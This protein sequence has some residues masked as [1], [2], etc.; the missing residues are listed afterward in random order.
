MSGTDAIL[1]TSSFLPGRGGIE[2]YLAA[3]ADRL[4]P[5]LAVV[6]PGQRDGKPLPADLP[7]PTHPLEW[8]KSPGDL[9]GQ[10]THQARLQNTDRVL[11]GTPWP[12]ALVA[13]RLRAEGLRYAVVVH[14]AELTAPGS[15]PILARKMAAALAGADL[16]LPVSSYTE[17]RIRRLLGK[18][19]LDP[20][21]IAVA[22]AGIDLERFRPDVESRGVKERHGLPD[23]RPLLL[24]LGRL[25]P[26]KGTARVIK[27]LPDVIRRVPDATLVVA[28]TGPQERKLRSLAQD[29][30]APVL[31]AGAVPDEDLPGLYA[32]ADIYV[33]GVADRWGGLEAEGLGIV[34]LEASACATPCVTGRSGGTPEA[35]LDGETGYVV[36]ARHHGQL[37]NALVTLLEDPAEAERMGAMARSHV[38]TAYSGKPPAELLDWLEAN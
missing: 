12:L 5:R 3:L 32:L 2:T 7:Y 29:L 15:V 38:E 35:V 17:G 19:R 22:R 23:D 21:P 28:G 36:D 31:F 6:A 37:V 27:A 34:L 14:G 20:P 1:L 26:R 9:V 8:T 18:H 13:P 16:L 25:V 11:L 4:A 10:I 33:L 30:G 24:S